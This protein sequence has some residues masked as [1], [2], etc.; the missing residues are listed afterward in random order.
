MRV[1]TL[2][3]TWGE[4]EGVGV[5]VRVRV[6]ELL[7]WGKDECDYLWLPLSDTL[8]GIPYPSYPLV[9]LPLPPQNPYPLWGV[10]VLE[11]RGKGT[12]FLPWGYPCQ[13]L[14]VSFFVDHP[15]AS[16]YPY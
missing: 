11:G 1:L 9:P 5:G 6:R 13:S 4:G 7:C 12:A 14:L 10:G 3:R 16:Q 15:F 2:L 8:G